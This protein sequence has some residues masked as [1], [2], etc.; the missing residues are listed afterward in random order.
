MVD[1]QEMEDVKKPPVDPLQALGVLGGVSLALPA[2]Y[3]LGRGALA[4]AQTGGKWLAKQRQ[5]GGALAPKQPSTG[6]LSH[7]EAADLLNMANEVNKGELA[8]SHKY[9]FMPEVI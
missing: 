8:M 7:G 4:A 1:K 5:P 6:S 3:F 9:G 2:G